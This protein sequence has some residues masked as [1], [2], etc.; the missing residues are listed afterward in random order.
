ME[1]KLYSLRSAGAYERLLR[2]FKA[3]CDDSLL[4]LFNEMA[5]RKAFL[6]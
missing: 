5:K 2:D 3:N 1:Q 4:A 6:Y